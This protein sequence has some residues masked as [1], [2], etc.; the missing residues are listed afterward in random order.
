MVHANQPL[1][2]SYNA[3]G[4]F[5]AQAACWVCTTNEPGNGSRTNLVHECGRIIDI[6]APIIGQFAMLGNLRND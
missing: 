1:F 6:K 4:F 2:N 3:L 5:I